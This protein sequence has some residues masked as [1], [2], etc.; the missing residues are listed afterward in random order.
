MPSEPRG[1]RTAA[2]GGGGL[3]QRL[4][5]WP[6]G[7]QPAH[8]GP[9]SPPPLQAQ[10]LGWGW[11]SQ[12]VRQEDVRA[13]LQDELHH[14]ILV[15][16]VMAC[17][18]PP[19]R[20]T[21]RGPE[22]CSHSALTCG[23]VLRAQSPCSGVGRLESMPRAGGERGWGP[24]EPPP[25]SAPLPHSQQVLEEHPQRVVIRDERSAPGPHTAE[26]LGRIL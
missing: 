5:V 14:L 13:L 6:C 24:S 23:S 17:W 3:S 8:A 1:C 21:Q 7:L 9:L 25:H 22:D 11:G 10:Q 18:L 15:T 16:M 2:A 19:S 12:S 26:A 4:T 20:A